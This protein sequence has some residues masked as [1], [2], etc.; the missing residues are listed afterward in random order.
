MHGLLL[1]FGRLSNK[2]CLGICFKKKPLV[3]GNDSSDHKSLVALHLMAWHCIQDTTLYSTLRFVNEYE[4]DDDEYDDDD[5]DTEMQG[6]PK[7][8]R[9]SA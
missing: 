9:F 1:I 6:S 2:A 8:R 7:K 3:I 5:D 4:Y